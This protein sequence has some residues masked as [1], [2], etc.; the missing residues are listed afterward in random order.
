MLKVHVIGPVLRS[1]TDDHSLR[2]GDEYVLLGSIYNTLQADVRFIAL[3]PEPDEEL[4]Q[5]A[6]G[7]LVVAMRARIAEADH[8]AWVYHKEAAGATEAGLAVAAG[9]PLHIFANETDLPR[10]S[11]SGAARPSSIRQDVVMVTSAP[12]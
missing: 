4:D 6:P 7:E 9:K 11:S 1:E 3:L 12:P 8:V 2:L 5:L 10:I